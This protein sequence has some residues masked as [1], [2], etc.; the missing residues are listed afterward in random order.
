[1]E[2]PPRQTMGDYCRRIDVGHIS[3]GFQSTNHVTF[4]IKNYMLL[5]LRDNMFDNQ[6]IRD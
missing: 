5:G 2:N 4:D 3:L 6:A 1:M